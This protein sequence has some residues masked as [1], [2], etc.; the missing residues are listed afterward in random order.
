MLL[1]QKAIRNWSKNSLECL[2]F[3]VF[4]NLKRFYSLVTPGT[5]GT[6]NLFI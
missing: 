2:E 5:L 6:P 1:L 3:F 4:A